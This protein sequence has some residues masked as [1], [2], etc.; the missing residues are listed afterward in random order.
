M[1]HGTEKTRWTL[2]YAL[3]DGPTSLSTSRDSTSTFDYGWQVLRLAVRTDHPR[4]LEARSLYADP[5]RDA[6][7]AIL[8]AV[9][10]HSRM[11]GFEPATAP[12]SARFVEVPKP[13][14]LKW[15]TAFDGHSVA[16]QRALDNTAP[17]RTLRVEWD[18]VASTFEL[19]WQGGET[20]RSGLASTWHTV[21]EELGLALS[22]FPEAL[23]IEEDWHVN[24]DELDEPPLTTGRVS[25]ITGYQFNIYPPIE[26]QRGK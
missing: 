25:N 16:P 18:Y 6:T 17:I 5:Q 9:F 14:A 3:W 8:R 24:L 21:W 10:W 26:K 11:I 1:S 7:T 12:V 4:I 15:V 2:G 22:K 23:D 13:K 20:E 19:T